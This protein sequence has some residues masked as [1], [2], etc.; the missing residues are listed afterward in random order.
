M[1]TMND[2]PN[3]LPMAGA[4]Q[5]PPPVFH[6]IVIV[7]LGLIGGSIALAARKAWPGALVIGVDRHEVLEQAMVRHAID[8]ASPDLMIASEA[9]LVVLATPV[10]QI[11][12][13][14]PRLDAFVGTSALVTDVG[15]TKR[16]ILEAA[17]ALPARLPFIGG[18]PLAGAARSGIETARPDLFVGRPWLLLPAEPGQEALASKLAEFVAG[19]G[20]EPTPVPSAEAHDRLV[21]IMSHLPQL[22]ASVLMT[23]IGDAIGDEGLALTGRGL[24]DATRL[25]ASPASVWRDV[26]S[27]NA[28]EIGSALDA[29]IASLQEVRGGLRDGAAVDNLF[30]RANRWRDR[31]EAVAGAKP[32]RP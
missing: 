8:V 2:S 20:A 24:R 32:D 19:L 13:T 12:D 26:C 28:D 18:H 11:L 7:G 31:L 27:T 29:V 25:A 15:S 3:L 30:D 1:E 5:G 16:A 6:H 23:V 4:P 17:A 14:L 9:D 10:S 22:T 21:A